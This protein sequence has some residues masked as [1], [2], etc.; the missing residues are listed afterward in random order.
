[1][2]NRMFF[3][4]FIFFLFTQNAL[5]HCSKQEGHF[6]F[7]E[8]IES[9]V[10]STRGYVTN[11]TFFQ[12]D[13][14]DQKDCAGPSR[15]DTGDMPRDGTFFFE[16]KLYVDE[17]LG[18]DNVYNLFYGSVDDTGSSCSHMISTS[19]MCGKNPTIFWA[20]KGHLDITY[21]SDPAHPNEFSIYRMPLS[22]AYGEGKNGYEGSDLLLYWG[23]KT[24]KTTTRPTIMMCIAKDVNGK[25]GD[26][27]IELATIN[28]NGT[29]HNF[30][31]FA[32]NI[33]KE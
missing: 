2:Y 31:I 33:E 3:F 15:L 13:A 14:A 25:Q 30:T 12:E 4:M 9:A 23:G 7:R 24:C 28:K 27:H 6:D 21:V 5:A 26:I 20:V 16:P 17:P 32:R 1:M 8:L 29:E 10:P 11:A 22:F 18:S 19:N